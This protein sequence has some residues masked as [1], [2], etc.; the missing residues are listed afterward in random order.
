MFKARKV[1]GVLMTLCLVTLATGC[2]KKTPSVDSLVSSPFSGV[3]VTSADVNFEVG[4]KVLPDGAADS[5]TVV[6]SL[7]FN[8][9]TAPDIYYIEGAVKASGGVE[10][11]NAPLKVYS[12]AD[13]TGKSV[14]YTW[15]TEGGR[16]V[17]KVVP[18]G[19]SYKI[20]SLTNFDQNLFMSYE[21]GDSTGTDYIIKAQAKAGTVFES[22]GVS[23][24]SSLMGA[25]A[26]VFKDASFD[27]VLTYDASSKQLKSAVFTSGTPISKNGVSVSDFT[28]SVIVNSV[29]ATELT[30]PDDVKSTAVQAEGNSGVVSGSGL[31]LGDASSAFSDLKE[32]EDEE[33][34]SGNTEIDETGETEA[35]KEEF[36]NP[37]F[38]PYEETE[39]TQ[40]MVDPEVRK[41]PKS[42][43]TDTPA[44]GAQTF[45]QALFGDAS[46]TVEDIRYMIAQEY[47]YDPGDDITYTLESWL[48]NS[49]E[50]W[51]QTSGSDMWQYLGDNDKVAISLLYKF[52]CLGDEFAA[53]AGLPVDEMKALVDGVN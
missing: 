7:S 52:G 24:L 5:E 44:T 40:N 20:A 14:D 11:L 41:D 43:H 47:G 22:L 46:Y 13:A 32:G 33:Q 45:Y 39:Y 2:G 26:D 36:G 3:E 49:P 4:M 19:E 35:P 12:V 29:N 37:A 42:M 34:S 23:S 15:D 30:L 8:A 1:A 38:K 6:S 17:Y 18:A 9:K 16:W 25:N 28:L 10:D 27:A 48:Q 31:G 51:L 21:L 53:Q 50:F